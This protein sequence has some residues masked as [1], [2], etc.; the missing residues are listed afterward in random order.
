MDL[1]DIISRLRGRAAR[2]VLLLL[3]GG[4]LVAPR[5]TGSLVTATLDRYAARVQQRLERVVLF[6]LT[7]ADERAVH[8]AH[9]PPSQKR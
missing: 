5:P 8:P 9:R 4:M 7:R 1:L 3:V 2:L 6:T